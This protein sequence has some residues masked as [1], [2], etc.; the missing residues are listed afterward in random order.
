[1]ALKQAGVL[2]IVETS[3]GSIDLAGGSRP[4]ISQL[5]KGARSHLRI[6]RKVQSGFHKNSTVAYCNLIIL[7]NGFIL[8]SPFPQVYYQLFSQAEN[9]THLSPAQSPNRVLPLVTSPPS[10][11]R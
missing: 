9:N 8:D 7:Q 5:L 1:M 2:F 11:I 6:V 4:R 3:R 10:S